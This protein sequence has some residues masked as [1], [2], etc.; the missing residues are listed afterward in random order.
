MDPVELVAHSGIV[1]AVGTSRLFF[2][3]SLSL[4]SDVRHPTAESAGKP[5]LT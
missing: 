2:R 3:L 1:E 5:R 4:N